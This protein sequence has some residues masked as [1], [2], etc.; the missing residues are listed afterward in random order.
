ETQSGISQEAGACPV[1][2]AESAS[3]PLEIFLRDES[4]NAEKVAGPN[5]EER[6]EPSVPMRTS[7]ARSSSSVSVG[8]LG[9]STPTQSSETHTQW[10]QFDMVPQYQDSTALSTVSEDVYA[11]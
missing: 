4:W 11:A 3:S 7:P 5:D 10:K 8:R 2:T 9:R 1:S 6:G